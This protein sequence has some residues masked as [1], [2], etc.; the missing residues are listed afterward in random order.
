MV[1]VLLALWLDRLA[2]RHILL[3]LLHH[4]RLGVRLLRLVTHLLLHLRHLLHQLSWLPEGHSLLNDHFQY[5]SILRV[6]HL[7]HHDFRILFSKA[8][9]IKPVR[10]LVEIEAHLLQLLQEHFSLVHKELRNVSLLKAGSHRQLL[11]KLSSLHLSPR[12]GSDALLSHPVKHLARKFLKGLFSE[13]TRIVFEF[14]EGHELDYICFTV[15][16]QARGV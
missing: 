4:Y 15:L 9:F 13:E 5:I 12:V 2:H 16:P 14:V 8:L 3:L 7:V 11:L 1:R 6:L 10:H